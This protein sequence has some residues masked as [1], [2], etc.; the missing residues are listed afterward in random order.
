MRRLSIGLFGVFCTFSII[1]FSVFRIKPI[2]SVIVKP[3]PAVLGEPT[4]SL[5]LRTVHIPHGDLPLTIQV[6]SVIRAEDITLHSNLNKTETSVEIMTQQS[7]DLLINGTFYT[8]ENTHGGLF[9]S[10][11]EEVQPFQRNSTYNSIFSINDLDTPRITSL[12]PQDKLRIALQTGPLLWTNGK[13][14]V[15]KMKTDKPARRMIAGV[16]GENKVVF[17][18]MYG[19]KSVFT[20]PYLEDVPALLS[21]INDELD[22][23][24]A[25]ATNLDGGTASVF[26]TQSFSLPEASSIGSYFCTIEN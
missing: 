9:I 7:C 11:Y 10:E 14:T 1:A 13:P 5:E 18:T 25:D 3:T 6:S 16:T 20:G 21:Q 26:T 22:L 23:S 2:E 12:V 19:T 8:T 4:S 15:L 17:I 24:L